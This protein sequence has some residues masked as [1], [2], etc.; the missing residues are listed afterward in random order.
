MNRGLGEQ[1]TSINVV[2]ETRPKGSGDMEGWSS[3]F[4]SREHN[5]RGRLM[6]LKPS[7]RPGSRQ[8]LNT[9]AVLGKSN[10]RTTLLRRST[11]YSLGLVL[12]LKTSTI[13]TFQHEASSAWVVRISDS[14]DVGAMTRYAQ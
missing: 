6:S 9:P 12:A 3:M 2:V 7:G 5:R 1:Q 8:Y 10:A 4:W 13:E 14:E 11:S